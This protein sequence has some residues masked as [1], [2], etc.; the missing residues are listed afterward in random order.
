[1]FEV[2]S[3]DELRSLKRQGIR[4][5]HPVKSAS[6]S[7]T[8]VFEIL[9]DA[10]VQEYF[11]IPATV[12][13]TRRSHSSIT[14]AVPK[15]PVCFVDG[16]GCNIGEPIT[17]LRKGLR[18]SLQK[19]NYALLSCKYE[20]GKYERIVGE[21]G[22]AQL[23]T[24]ECLEFLLSIPNHYV[25]TSFG[26][27]YDVEQILR[28]LPLRL[29]EIL[30]RKKWVKWNKYQLGYV[31]R[32]Y[33]YIGRRKRNKNNRTKDSRWIFDIIGF[34]NTSFAK[35]TRKWNVA[36]PEEQA[37]LEVMKKARPD[38]GPVTEQVMEY[39]ELEGSLGIRAFQK[40]RDEWLSL[41]LRIRSPHGAGSLAK[42]LLDKNDTERFMQPQI[43][44]PVS[45]I[46]RAYYGGRFDFS[47][48]GEFAHAYESDIN[49]AYPFH[50]RTLPCL[51]HIRIAKSS[52]FREGNNGVWYIR[53]R[54]RDY[55]WGLFPYR[56]NGSIY[57]HNSGNGWY[58]GA[59]VTSALRIDPTIEILDGYTFDQECECQPFKWIQEYYDRRLALK[60]S[61]PFT[62]EVIK[63]GMNSVYGKLAQ[64][65]G[66]IP[67]HQCLLWAGMIT[68]QTRAQLLDAIAL[69]PY[70]IIAL[71]TDSVL[72]LEPLPLNHSET[73]LG[74]W[75]QKELHNVI[76]LGNGYVDSDNMEKS[77]HR[78]FSKWDWT[79]ARRQWHE[80]GEYLLFKLEFLKAR[81]AIDQ[82]NEELRGIWIDRETR[83][84]FDLP[85]G[86]M[87]ETDGWI[88]PSDNPNPWKMSDERE[89]PRDNIRW[90]QF[91]PS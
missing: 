88:Y 24:K 51:T 16:E 36:T 11:G 12:A 3:A 54:D 19:Q 77:T 66:F 61:A 9:S 20:D 91:G 46:L 50:L 83:V 52:R 84:T 2:L 10:E 49:S 28:D 5:H 89:V 63:I 7:P 43:A 32:K 80:S 73:E 23:S 26:F 18:Y 70:S 71:S 4:N 40:I 65:K 14:K 38:F 21:N 74:A 13:R 56:D 42:A 76:V 17:G 86:R 75:K 72:S 45:P 47:R 39:N 85:V 33:F 35:V 87:K 59:E 60:Q 25:I 78:G 58:Y 44:V 79:E 90:S 6:G 30:Y 31:P 68:S 82:H 15:L 81:D 55:P 27:E 53:W 57:Y 64:T 22:T 41:G 29:M 37:F 34:W 1:M 69:N 8:D 67:P 62:A 48:Q